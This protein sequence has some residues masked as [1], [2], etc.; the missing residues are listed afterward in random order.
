V[1]YTALV[2]D[3]STFMRAMVG[4][5]L[6]KADIEIVGEAETGTQ[7]IA[8]YE[9]L[10]PDIVTM[11]IVMPEMSGVDAARTICQKDPKAKILMCS[12]I[13]QQS[14]VAEAI[15]AGAKDFIVKPFQAARVLEAV[16]QILA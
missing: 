6:R 1:N 10:R 3:D 15:E 8:E 16:Q 13:G 11:D 2:C 5:I 12:A 7:A 4:D 14:L 9:R